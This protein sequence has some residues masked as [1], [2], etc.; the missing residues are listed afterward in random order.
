[1]TEP[2]AVAVVVGIVVSGDHRGHE[3]GFPTANVLSDVSV[4]LPDDGVYAGYVERERG[5]IH[6]AAISIGRRPTYYEAGTRLVEAHLL[7]FDDDLYG[8]LLKVTVCAKVREQT[9]FSSSEEL[10]AQIRTD[11]A[12]VREVLG[13]TREW[14]EFEAHS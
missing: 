3:L 8:E 13:P 5:S 4:D 12:A 6:L 2:H 11:V 1:M 10:V 14:G 7:D 9:K